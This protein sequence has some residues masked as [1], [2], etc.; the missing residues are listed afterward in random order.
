MKANNFPFYF[1]CIVRK[2][3]GAATDQTLMSKKRSAGAASDSLLLL[4]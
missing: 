3:R 4:A 2:Q 1:D